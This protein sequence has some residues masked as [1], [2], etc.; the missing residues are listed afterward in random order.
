MGL[1]LSDPSTWVLDHPIVRRAGDRV[2]PLMR[3][4]S[5]IWCL[6]PVL[7]STLVSFCSGSSS[8]SQGHCSPPPSLLP[9]WMQPR[10]GWD[11]GW[12]LGDVFPEPVKTQGSSELCSGCP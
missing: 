2:F 12:S 11:I 1:G 7:A 9:L 3:D 10:E 6:V 4:S 5:C 8:R